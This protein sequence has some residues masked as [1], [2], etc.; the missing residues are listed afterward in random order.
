MARRVM[1]EVRFGSDV[2]LSGRHESV[3]AMLW[4]TIANWP[5]WVV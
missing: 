2:Y 5:L 1:Q 3:L 4:R